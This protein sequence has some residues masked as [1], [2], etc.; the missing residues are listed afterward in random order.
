M[1]PKRIPDP[2]IAY[3]FPNPVTS[4]L[5]L[6]QMRSSASHILGPVPILV[7]TSPIHSRKLPVTQQDWSPGSLML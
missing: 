6:F 3:H 1:C 5:Y 4:K 7:F 2:S